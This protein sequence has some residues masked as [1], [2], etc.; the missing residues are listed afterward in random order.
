MVLKALRGWTATQ[1]NVTIAAYLGW[2]LDAFDFLMLTLVTKDIAEEFGVKATALGLVITATLALRPVGAF[3]FGRLAD[4]F[5]R[6]PILM[7]NVLTYSLLAF[8][9]AFAPDFTTFLILRCLFGVAMGGEWGVGSSLAMEHARPESRGF[10]SGLLQTG[11]PTGGLLAAGAAAIF[12][13]DHGWRFLVMLSVVPALLVVFIRM[14]VPE[15]PAWKSGAAGKSMAIKPTGLAYGLIGVT[16]AIAGQ[17]S[18]FSENMSLGL[19]MPVSIALVVGGIGLAALAF[20]RQHWGLALFA[21]V[22]M[23]G[24]NSLSHGTQDFYSNFLRI[25]HGFDPGIASLIIAVGSFGAI[26]GGI[27]SGTLSQ[28]IGRRRMI[29]IGALLVIPMIPAWAFFAQTPVQFM[30]AVFAIQFCV[31]G[32]WGVVPAH[33][34]ELSPNDVRGTFPGFVYQVGNLLS[35][36]VP[37]AQ[38]YLVEEHTWKYGEALALVAVC[39]GLGIAFLVNLG[40][41]GRHVVMAGDSPTAAK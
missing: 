41:E 17:L 12:L 21:M 22:M 16:L 4:R 7:L 29:T 2:T 18:M 15:S 30:F 33:L 38:T 40:P 5:G 1:R 28:I 35:A 13:Q 27:T 19:P 11:Y 3:I 24:F 20:G 14:G 31:Q 26:C 8:A 9:S 23:A 37:Y 32:A 25:Q 39:A 10:V 36:A 34:N 6:R